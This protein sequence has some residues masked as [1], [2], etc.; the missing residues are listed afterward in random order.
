MQVV[1]KS[2]YGTVGLEYSMLASNKFS[3]YQKIVHSSYGNEYPKL[4]NG[5]PSGQSS[6]F[7][8]VPIAEQK[9]TD[10]FNASQ[11]ALKLGVGTFIGLGGSGHWV[12]T[13]ELNL[14]IPL[15]AFFT[16]TTE[17]N[18]KNGY[19]ATYPTQPA[20]VA[21]PKLWYFSFSV[22]LKFPLGDIQ[23]AK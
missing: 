6:G 15:S 17:S 12:L 21:T 7:S 20:S 10:Y 11:L 2:F 14:G 16:S 4:L 8:E 3:G 18:Y 5:Q 22:A 1:P 19:P 9:K 23:S 13:P